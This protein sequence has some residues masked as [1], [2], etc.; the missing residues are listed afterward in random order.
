MARSTDN[1]EPAND[2]YDPVYLHTRRE[3][4]VILI[5]WA[6]AL[7][8]SVSVCTLFGYGQAAKGEQVQ[9]FFGM[10]AWVFWGVMCPWVTAGL[11]SIVFSLLVMADDDLGP[12]T[13]EDVDAIDT[14]L[15]APKPADE[16]S[17]EEGVDD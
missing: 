13:S 12:D 2:Q 6:V 9:L 5:V 15:N 8:W 17:S 4:L 10:P 7:V 14:A 3:S 11:F 16:P 1:L